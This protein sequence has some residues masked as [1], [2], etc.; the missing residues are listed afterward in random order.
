MAQ[1]VET[2]LASSG[3]KTRS[4]KLFISI[5]VRVRVRQAVPVVDFGQTLASLQMS[6]PPS[7]AVDFV[8][9]L[10]YSLS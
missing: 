7:L 5:G 4:A 1:V 3:L 6:K 9:V 2:D 8:E 10:G